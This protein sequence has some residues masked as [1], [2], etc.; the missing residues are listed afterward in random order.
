MTD[1]EAI[2]LLEEQRSKIGSLKSRMRGSQEFK[3]WHRDTRVAVQKVFGEQ[4]KHILEF[5]GIRYNPSVNS[6]FSTDAALHTRYLSGLESADAVL[7]SMIDEIKQFGLR[8]K[9][10]VPWEECL[11]VWKYFFE[12]APRGI[13]PGSDNI[14]EVCK[15]LDIDKTTAMEIGSQLE[16]ED[17]IRLYGDGEF[18][19][20]QQGLRAINKLSSQPGGME[21]SCKIITE[22]NR[23]E[24]ISQS[25]LNELRA[26]HPANFDLRRLIRLCEEID[27]SFR[28]ECWFAVAALTRALMDHV[29]PI[30]HRKTFEEIANNYGGTKSF[31]GSMQHLQES[32]RKIADAHLHTL[33]RTK[34]DLPTATQVNFGPDLDVLLSEI[35]RILR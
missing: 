12:S 30:F 14:I 17:Y 25:R 34:E 27:I 20:K 33:I 31:K 24:Y 1:L 32:S 5:E 8:E 29:P 7:E 22:A 6:R 10:M 19:V 26:L 4:S 16:A 9:D 35:V 28:N 23:H 2:S 15:T 3:K 18:T 21:N 11:R 13:P